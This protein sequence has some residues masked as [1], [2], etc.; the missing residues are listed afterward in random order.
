VIGVYERHFAPGRQFVEQSKNRIAEIYHTL[1]RQL[2]SVPLLE[3]LMG[4]NG[5]NLMEAI[6][7]VDLPPDEVGNLFP[8]ETKTP[9]L[10]RRTSRMSVVGADGNLEVPQSPTSV[11]TRRT[12]RTGQSQAPSR[13]GMSRPPPANA[14]STA[15]LAAAAPAPPA[16]QDA[17][18][19]HDLF[20][21]PLV[22][23]ISGRSAAHRPSDANVNWE[24]A[25]A[26]LKKVETLLEAVKET[27]VVKL[28]EDIKEL[29]VGP[30]VNF[31]VCH[32]AERFTTL[33]TSNPD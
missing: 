28:R 20:D 2:R 14:T 33:G 27:P 32:G 18:I 19:H 25:V 6:F 9:N 24:E 29:Q 16:D 11:T 7:Q 1:P 23:L 13:R 31:R 12:G 8:E 17:P 10:S 30:F 4:N 22:R 5:A 21:S 3:A 15:N 26:S